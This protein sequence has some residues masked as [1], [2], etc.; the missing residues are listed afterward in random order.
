MWLSQFQ[1]ARA[2]I[3]L[4]RIPPVKI[5]ITEPR[6]SVL[7]VSNS[8]PVAQCER[9]DQGAE[10]WTLRSWKSKRWQLF[11]VSYEKMV[12][13]VKTELGVPTGAC[14]V[15]TFELSGTHV[16][17]GRPHALLSPCLVL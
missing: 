7:T 8:S 10:I 2:I 13:N 12:F 16:S 15:I 11:S 5:A 4:D 17:H 1:A 14:A 6:H 3:E 9:N